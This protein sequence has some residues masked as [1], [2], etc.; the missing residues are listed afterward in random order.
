MNKNDKFILKAKKREL[1]TPG[2]QPNRKLQIFVEQK[3]NPQNNRPKSKNKVKNLKRI[4]T[5]KLIFI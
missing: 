4:I 2:L 5:L 1:N 3:K